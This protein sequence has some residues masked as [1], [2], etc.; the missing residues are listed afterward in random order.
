MSSA[1]SRRAAG[2]VCGLRRGCAIRV[3]GGGGLGQ[4]HATDR[5]QHV[6]C[7]V[8]QRARAHRKWYR[9]CRSVGRPWLASD[10]FEVAPSFVCVCPAWSRAHV[11]CARPREIKFIPVADQMLA[12]QAYIL[13]PAAIAKI[14][15]CLRIMNPFHIF[16]AARHEKTTPYTPTNWPGAASD[17]GAKSYVY[18]NMPC[19]AANG[20]SDFPLVFS[21]C[22]KPF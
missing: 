15:F 21:R 20:A 18:D 7:P 17:R 11:T 9:R 22:L 12:V 1:Q 16:F 10:L 8:V 6:T 19:F 13:V 2:F 3:W 14:H 5:Q 4:R